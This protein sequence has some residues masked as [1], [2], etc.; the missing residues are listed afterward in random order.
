VL[1]VVAAALLQQQIVA[2]AAETLRLG[3]LPQMAAVSAALVRLWAA[4]VGMEAVAQAQM[5]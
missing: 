4:P 3:L 1:V 2:L 5:L